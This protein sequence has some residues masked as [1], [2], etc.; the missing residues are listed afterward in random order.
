VRA[1]RRG[2]RTNV[3]GIR[4]RSATRG[5][6]RWEVKALVG[7]P[8]VAQDLER[9]LLARAGILG[10]RANPVSGRLLI[11]YVPDAT[12][13]DAESLI[14]DC[15]NG[16]DLSPSRRSS[17]TAGKHGPLYRV[18]K[19]SLPERS[20]LS[21][22]LALSV[23]GQSI[24]LL[25][26]TSLIATVSTVQRGE[27]PGFLRFFGVRKQRSQLLFMTAMSLVLAG[28]D[29][30]LQYYRKRAWRRL[31]LATQHRLRARLY[32]RIQSQDM[33]FFDRHG[34]GRLIKLVNEDTAR[35][36]EFIDRAGDS[37]IERVLLIMVAGVGLAKASPRLALF[38][39]VPL[40]IIVPATR[41]FQRAAGKQY[42]RLGH[43]SGSY[44]QRLENTLSGVAEVKSFTA[45][46]REARHLHECDR[47]L[48]EA[49]F[50][51][52]ST[53]SLLFHIAQST[54]YLGSSLMAGY[55]GR[56]HLKGKITADE[57][58][59]AIYWFPHLLGAIT[60][61]EEV[62][63]LYHSASVSAAQLTEVLDS[64]PRIRS[65]RVRLPAGS[66]RGGVVFENVSFGYN[67]SVKVLKDVS[68]ELRPGETLGIVGPTGSGKSTLLR[69][70]LRFY[71]VDSGRILLDGLD[72]RQLNLRELRK[73]ISLVS[74]DVYL[75]P[76]TVR[77]NVLYGRP[78]STKA[79]IV[80]ALNE[81][82]ALDLLE[83]LPGGL[84]TEVGE[85]GHLL[86]GGERQRVAIARAL[87][88]GAPILM[89]DEA[90]S[91][92]DYE[93]EFAVKRSLQRVTAKRSVLVIAHR[94]ST[95]RD[96]D[97]IIVFE[98]GKISEVG[99]H[100][101]LLARRGLYASLWAFQSGEQS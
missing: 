27:G 91:H 19:T 79:Q 80:E 49:S 55:G 63:R 94:L 8:D 85:R 18:L 88:K 98:K 1:D 47:E 89:L 90:T 87:L 11:L 41:F 17:K 60:G 12:G 68:F 53:S 43:V 7:R 35:I 96:A 13:L 30:L 9:A 46:R 25:Q 10:A 39:L 76:G 45:E 62:T 26:V 16:I 78:Q 86:S 33:E 75:F 56:I 22:P 83:S 84:E 23:A 74:Q 73:A 44:S 72:I 93:T 34:T 4:R 2:S 32:A 3:W 14:K 71:D 20:Q 99:S 50:A 64:R 65:G 59:R 101:E 100:R 77:E 24:H 58:N 52:A 37:T 51:A 40:S 54:Y 6:E 67:A 57:Y 42:A 82:G 81:A 21:T 31:A 28:A 5:R 70:L 66:V 95:I 38:T 69:L 61:V 36:G 97:R 29:L 92:L 15:L 48:G